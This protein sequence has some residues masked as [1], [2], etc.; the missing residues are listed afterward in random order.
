MVTERANALTVGSASDRRVRRS[1][2][3]GLRG[4]RGEVGGERR[5][6]AKLKIYRTR[7]ASLVIKICVL[8][9][10]LLLHKKETILAAFQNHFARIIAREGESDGGQT[11]KFSRTCFM[12]HDP[13]L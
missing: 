2:V 5:A 4:A 8:T 3:N 12:V 7:E 1:G 10:H 11:S 13:I 6:R 9:C